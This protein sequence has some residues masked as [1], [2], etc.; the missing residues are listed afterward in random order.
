MCAMVRTRSGCHPG[1]IT[2][3]NGSSVLAPAKAYE[4]SVSRVGSVSTLIR[5]TAFRNAW[6]AEVEPTSSVQP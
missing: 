5:F 2:A 3:Q 1:A 4:V 6:A